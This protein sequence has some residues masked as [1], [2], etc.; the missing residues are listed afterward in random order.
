M[1]TI[2]TYQLQF[3]IVMTFILIK[4]DYLNTLSE[5]KLFAINRR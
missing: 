2:K 3:W 5:V 1:F 4:L